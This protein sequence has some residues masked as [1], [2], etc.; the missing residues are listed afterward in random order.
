MPE[1]IKALM[2]K[3]QVVC[4]ISK[5]LSPTR[6]CDHKIPLQTNS[7]HVKVRPYRFPHSQKIEIEAMVEQMLK[8]RLI[9]MSN[10]PFSSPFILV[11]K[12]M[13]HGGSAQI[14]D[15]LMQ[16]LLKMYTLYQL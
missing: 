14:I 4:D 1:T 10:S 2:L 16:L 8:D 6:V 15:L 9:E 5:C 7:N 11:E 13:E 3:Y 12:K